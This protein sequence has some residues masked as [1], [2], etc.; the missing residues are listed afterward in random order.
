MTDD[1]KGEQFIRA[2]PPGKLAELPRKGS[3]PRRYCAFGS[4][5]RQLGPTNST[6]LCLTHNH[7]KGYCRCARCMEAGD[8]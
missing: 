1:W 8:D 6:G 2:A 7:S 4:C 5:N 3:R